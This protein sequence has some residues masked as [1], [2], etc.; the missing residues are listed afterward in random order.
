MIEPYQRRVIEER[1]QLE[2]RIEKLDFFV[3]ADPR[4]DENLDLHERGRLRTQLAIMRAYST[5]LAERIA[6]FQT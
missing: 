1:L 5:I 4:F 3:Y 2:E 6:N